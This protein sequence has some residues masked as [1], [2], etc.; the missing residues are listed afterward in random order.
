MTGLSTDRYWSLTT[1]DGLVEVL[2]LS[3]EARTVYAATFSAPPPYQ[4]LPDPLLSWLL[5]RSHEV[6]LETFPTRD[7]FKGVPPRN[8]PRRH[9][10]F[11]GDPGKPNT[12]G[13][14]V[15]GRGVPRE[16]H[17]ERMATLTSVNECQGAGCTGH[18]NRTSEVTVSV[19][20]FGAVSA[21]RSASAMRSACPAAS[22]E[23]SRPLFEP[24]PETMRA[25]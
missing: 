25:A 22:D 20:Y 8:R 15:D 16:E 6:T 4:Q 2:V 7:H 9:R 12:D 14:C 10:C 17:L 5:E 3:N 13:A 1:D 24:S 11:R 23:P 18:G 21:W 19:Y